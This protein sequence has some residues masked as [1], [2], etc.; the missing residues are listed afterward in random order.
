MKKV[1]III[2]AVVA[3]GTLGAAAARGVYSYINCGYNVFTGNY[4]NKGKEYAYG[5]MEDAYNCALF[6]LL[7]D[8]VE[9]RLGIYGDK[10]TLLRAEEIIKTNKENKENKQ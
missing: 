6:G 1:I 2:V 4:V 5:S 7:P 9:Q 8:L 3:G 10:D